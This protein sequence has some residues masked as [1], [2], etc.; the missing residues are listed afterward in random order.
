M[1]MK[2]QTVLSKENISSRL[3]K[4][5][6]PAHNNWMH[7]V[8]LLFL[9]TIYL[10]IYFISVLFI[11]FDLFIVTFLFT[12][13]SIFFLTR[14]C[15]TIQPLSPPGTAAQ[16]PAHRRP[17]RHWCPEAPLPSCPPSC[18]CCC[19]LPQGLLSSRLVYDYL[20]VLIGLLLIAVFFSCYSF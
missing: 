7:N 14:D 1:P 12:F 8:F 4:Y 15:L 5:S 11:S 19:L 18:C 3:Q 9:F 17:Q 10:F 16:A 13:V 6:R 2:T 20:W